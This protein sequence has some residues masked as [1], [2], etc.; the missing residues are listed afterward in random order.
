[1]DDL[2]RR[3]CFAPNQMQIQVAHILRRAWRTA[4]LWLA[5]CVSLPMGLAACGGS[6]SPSPPV[7]MVSALIGP[8]GGTV[9][10]P[11]GVQVVIPAGALTTPVTIGIAR[12]DAGAPAW[13]EGYQTKGPTYEFTPHGLIFLSPVTIRMPVPAGS[14][15][16]E[17]FMASP[18]EDWGLREAVVTSGMA[19]FQRNTFSYGAMGDACGWSPSDPNLDPSGCVATLTSHL[20]ARSSLPPAALIPHIAAT[21]TS[22]GSYELVQPATITLFTGYGAAADCQNARVIIKR[23]RIDIVPAQDYTT[24]FDQSVGLTSNN[25]GAPYRRGSGSTTV[26]VPFVQAD[27]GNHVFYTRFTCNRPGKV[28]RSDSDAVIIIAKFAAPTVSYSIGGAVSGLTGTGLVLQNNGGDNLPVSASGGAFTFATAIGSGSPYAVTVLTQPAGQTCTVQNGS[29]VANADVSNVAVSCSATTTPPATT[30]A[31]KLSS[32]WQHTCAVKA[33]ATLACWGSGGYGELGNKGLVNSNTP[34]AVTGLTGVTAVSAGAFS[35]CAIHDAGVVSCWGRI[36]SSLIPVGVALGGS[37]AVSVAMGWDH[38][39][40]VDAAGAVWCWGYNTKGELGDGSTSTISR[41]TAQP[42]KLASGIALSGAVA[43]VAGLELSCAQLTGGEVYCWG[44]DI[45]FLAR[46]APQRIQQ[47][48]SNSGASDFTVAGR[49]S[50]GINHVCGI[51]SVSFKPIC[52]GF[53]N[54]GQLGDGT[55]NGRN[56]AMTTPSMF[57]LTSIAAGGTHS[58]GILAT[59]MICWGTAPMGNGRGTETLLSPLDAGR[60]VSLYYVADPVIEAA[61]GSDHTCVLRSN[62]DVQCW[63]SNLYGQLGVGDTTGSFVPTSTTAGAV[64]WHP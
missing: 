45:S 59:D 13:S 14:T 54:D 60:P 56:Y 38:A 6:D 46:T 1:M 25:A 17:V 43:A 31:T 52:W 49:I 11:D 39:C 15:G 28:T 24:I 40:A 8:A 23:K 34:V 51:E 64:F 33:D 61:A 19:E 58:C 20:H 21:P 42:V 50:A 7:A 53:N 26:T 16:T 29:G 18:G 44:R 32:L 35:T 63:G 5:V 47:M 48:D 10:G 9:T 22:P 12:S 3:N 4:L 36:N 41:P 55:T 30:T 62:G 37:P 57:G 27:E 2:T